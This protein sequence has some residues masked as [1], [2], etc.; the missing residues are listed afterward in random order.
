MSLKEAGF[1]YVERKGEFRWVSPA[2]L[3][4]GD[5]DCTDMTDTEFE[6]HVSRVSSRVCEV[7]SRDEGREPGTL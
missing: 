7:V 5:I 3:E 1:R 2:M 4:P 6:E